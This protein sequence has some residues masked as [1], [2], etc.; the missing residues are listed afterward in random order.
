M[1]P[2]CVIIIV[3]VGIIVFYTQH[4]SSHYWFQ[5]IHMLHIY[6]QNFPK[7]AHWVIGHVEYIR[8]ER[9]IFVAGTYMVIA[10]QLKVAVYCFLT[11]MWNLYVDTVEVQFGIYI[12]CGRHICL[13]AYANN[14]K[15]I[16]TSTLGHI[17][18]DIDGSYAHELI[19]MWYLEA[20]LLLVHLESN[21]LIL[22]ITLLTCWL[23]SPATNEKHSNLCSL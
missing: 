6:W 19:N 3:R 12:Q 5:W 23:A 1:Q 9:G 21:T 10:L 13:W 7:D 15:C 20:Y 18:I 17:Y 16:Y 4:S 2:G 8:H 14:L 11:F 22:N